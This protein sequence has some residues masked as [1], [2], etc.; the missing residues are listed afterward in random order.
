MLAD[1]AGLA[2]AVEPHG[3][4]RWNVVFPPGATK[5]SE[6]C[7]VGQRKAELLAAVQATLGR[8]VNITFSVMPGEVSKP[9]TVTPQAVVK[10]QKIRELSEH[11]FIKKICEVLDGEV[12]R[13]DAPR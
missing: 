11:P 1:F 10:A 9:V 8:P 5:P 13:V 12:I 2:V 6:Y 3:S 7:E 4:D